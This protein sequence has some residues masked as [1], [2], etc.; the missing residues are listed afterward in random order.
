MSHA[1]GEIA[2]PVFRRVMEQSLRYLGA[3]PAANVAR[4]PALPPPRA[5]RAARP[6]PDP[7]RGSPPATAC[8]TC[9]GRPCAKRCARSSPHGLEAEWRA[10]G[11]WSRR[12]PP[13]G[14]RWWRVQPVR[15]RLEPAGLRGRPP[16]AEA[17]GDERGRRSPGAPR[18][19]SS[20]WRSSGGRRRRPGDARARRAPRL[21]RGGAGR[22]LRRPPRVAKTTAPASPRRRRPRGRCGA[23][24]SP[25]RR[26]RPVLVAPDV[27]RALAI[28]RARVGPPHVDARRLG[29]TG[30]NGKTTTAWLLE[31]ALRSLGARPG[32]LGTVSHRFGDRAWPALHTTP[33]ADD[34]ARRFAAMRDLGRDARGDGGE[35]PRALPRARRGGALSRRG[36]HQHHAGPPRFP[37][38]LRALRRRQGDPLR[39]SS[40]PARPVLNVDD[41]SG[42]DLAARLVD[43][44][45]TARGA[46][47]RR[48]G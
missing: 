13:R 24:R 39:P 18:S 25:A 42:A 6:R 16:R 27:E 15:L 35:L 11:W 43:A 10:A 8:P 34:L 33:E 23:L 30:T 14:R 36:A 28:A 37:R 41:P 3:L 2:A 47:T 20:R 45:P 40:V 38:H 5:R 44:S 26:R 46:P 31:H 4:T 29:I 12:S 7:S 48:C 19:G 17:G 21:P 22:P 1:G 9:T 32:L